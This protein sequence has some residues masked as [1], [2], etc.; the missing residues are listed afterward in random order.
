M[1]LNNGP[2]HRQ[3][4]SHP[5]ILCCV[6]GFEEPVRSLGF[7]T[8]SH[9]FHAKAHTISLVALGSDDQVSGTIADSAHRF[10]TISKQ[11]EYDLLKLDAIAHDGRK[12][13]SQLCAQLH[14][15]SLESA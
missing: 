12:V 11:V 15:A 3:S 8:Y 4:D 5:I 14:P 10:R 7:K 2:A 13:I 9:V 6:K 1:I